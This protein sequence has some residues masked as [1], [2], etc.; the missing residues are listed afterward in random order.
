MANSSN[1]GDSDSCSEN[2]GEN[3][4]FERTVQQV[5]NSEQLPMKHKASGLWDMQVNYHGLARLENVVSVNYPIR[6]LT[7]PSGTKAAINI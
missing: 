5:L 3:E 1:I 7:T 6:L 2:L 4:E